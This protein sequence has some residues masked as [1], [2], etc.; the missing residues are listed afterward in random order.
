ME[1]MM[2]KSVM[3]RWQEFNIELNTNSSELILLVEKYTTLERINTNGIAD[4]KLTFNDCEKDSIEG[5]IPHEAINTFSG[6]ML[7]EETR[8][9]LV[10]KL[11]NEK[12]SVYKEYGTCHINDSKNTIVSERIFKNVV[13]DYYSILLL[14]IKPLSEL[15]RKYGYVRF[16]TGCIK[17]KDNNCLISGISG[18]GKSTAT[19]SLLRKGHLVL[20]DEM[21]LL[22]KEGERYNAYSLSNIV[23]I[24][25]EAV[26]RFFTKDIMN[27]PHD[28]F[29]DEYYFQLSDIQS[30]TL[31]VASD[32]KNVFV[33]NITGKTDTK[34]HSVHPTQVIQELF[35][36]TINAIDEEK[37]NETFK[38]VMGFL[39]H[40][41]CYQIDFGTDMELFEKAMVGMEL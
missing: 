15:L 21:P 33:L 3:F 18:R 34:I 20:S 8:D 32:I 23:K 17:I 22:K 41:N 2:T 10:Y 27:L 14:M 39:N 13:F 25:E 36:V 28:C 6:K 26:K 1:K 16:H 9:Y 30:K 19:F 7:L 12:W 35:P 40:A 29:E 11:E 38:F 37:M 4:I 5:Q 24:R 31:K